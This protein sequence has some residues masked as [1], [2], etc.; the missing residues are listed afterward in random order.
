MVGLL[1]ITD[2]RFDSR[3]PSSYKETLI[4]PWCL[5]GL[6]QFSSCLEG[7][8]RDKGEEGCEQ[9]ESDA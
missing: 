2:K 4:T 5:A 6:N 1:A 8:G 3:V 7:Q 9:V